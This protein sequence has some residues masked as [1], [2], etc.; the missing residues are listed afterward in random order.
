WVSTLLLIFSGGDA[1]WLA[2]AL[3]FKACVAGGVA[4]IAPVFLP[5][6]SCR[7]YCFDVGCGFGSSN[8]RVFFSY[9]DIVGL[10][11]YLVPSVVEAVSTLHSRFEEAFLS[12]SW[13]SSGLPA[14]LLVPWFELASLPFVALTSSLTI[15]V[16]MFLY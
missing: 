3:H 11:H 1:M 13:Q 6:A 15:N 10:C 5:C 8:L 9:D 16:L 4:L 12:G 7:Y 14:P 2:S